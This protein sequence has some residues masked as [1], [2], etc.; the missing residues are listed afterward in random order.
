MP[1]SLL[2]LSSL[3]DPL[4]GFV[5]V[6]R[7]MSITQAAADLCLTQSAVSRQIQ[8]LEQRLG[9]KLLVRGHRSITLT[10]D[11]ERL[12]RS[13][14]Q[15]LQQLQ[16]TLDA[17]GD[18]APLRPVTVTASVGVTGLWLLPRLG[19]FQQQHPPIDLRIAASNRLVDIEREDIDLAIRYCARD[20]A[21]AGAI[22]LFDETVAPVAH[23]SLGLHI[24][25]REEQLARKALLEF[26]D[27]QRPWLHWR[28]WLASAGWQ[29]LKPRSIVRFNQYDQVVQSAMAGQGVALGRLPLLGPMLAERSLV[30]LAPVPAIRQNHH[31]YWL[32]QADQAPRANVQAVV[33]WLLEEARG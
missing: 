11:G 17:I 29:G 21:P 27:P 20:A 19:R 31:G 9:S 1:A 26:D 15:A 3:L 6:G 10:T 32:L 18:H 33:D 13:A 14:D 2:S 7:R 4:R 16:D 24:P 22:H 28:H 25:L 12:F 30:V 8:T 23:P 5:A